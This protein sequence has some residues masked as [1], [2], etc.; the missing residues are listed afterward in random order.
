MENPQQQQINDC[1]TGW[2][3]RGDYYIGDDCGIGLHIATHLWWSPLFISIVALFIHFRFYFFKLCSHSHKLKN[4]S[5]SLYLFPFFFVLMAIGTIILSILKLADSNNNMVG[6]SYPATIIKVFMFCS[7]FTG[8]NLYLQT[9]IHFFESY[10][11]FLDYTV[12]EDLEKKIKF[13]AKYSNVIYAIIVST[14]LILIIG[15]RFPEFIYPFGIYFWL[16]HLFIIVLF[17]YVGGFQF[18]LTMAKEL[19]KSAENQKSNNLK[20][21]SKVMYHCAIFDIV[22]CTLATM[23]YSLI[24]FVPYFQE[25]ACYLLPI[26]IT[27]AHI[28][29]IAFVI[30]VSDIKPKQKITRQLPILDIE[31]CIKERDRELELERQEEIEEKQRIVF[32]TKYKPVDADANADASMEVL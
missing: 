31:K 12:R 7:W 5:S 20:R 29:M 6:L 11:R 19:H 14:P 28:G 10:L 26:Q 2:I 21:I 25:R 22:V 3:N 15:V 13:V 30:T 8:G 17:G 4:M 9:I 18:M 23:T 27:L 1:P 16:M 32:F 24:L